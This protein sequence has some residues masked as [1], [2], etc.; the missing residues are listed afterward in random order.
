MAILVTGGTKGIGLAIATRFAKTGTDVFMNYRQDEEAAR[1]AERLVAQ[2]GGRPHLVCGDVSTPEGAREVLRAVAG[3]TDRLDQLVHCA[4][5][6]I[7]GPLLDMDPR[8]FT[9]ALTLN[10]TA[11]LYLVQEARPLLRRGSTVIFLSSRGGRVVIP[12]YAAVGVAKALAESLVRYMAVELAPLGVRA[13]CVAPT[14]IDTEALRSVFGSK[15]EDVLK[16]TDAGPSG[17]RLTDDDYLGLIEFLASPA[18]EMIQGQVIAVN[19]AHQL[20]A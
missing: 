5:R 17:R 18:A 8:A 11:L 9:D 10:G 12:N 4:V 16:S 20:M 15:T 1:Q 19:G 13:N 6:V 2:Q 14:A 7:T 3:R